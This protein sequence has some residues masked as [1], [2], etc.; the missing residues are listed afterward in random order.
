MFTGIIEKTGVIKK[1][2]PRYLIIGVE[3][4]LSDLKIGDSVAVNG[5]CLTIIKLNKNDFKVEIMPETLHLTNFFYLKQGEAVNLEKSLKAGD[6]LDGHFVLG[7]IDGVGKVIKIKKDGQFI[8]LIIKAPTNL[9]KYIA[10]KGAI[11]VNGIS[12]T[13]AEDLKNSFRVALITRTREVTNLKNIKEGDLV[14]LEID[15]LAR[16]LEKLSK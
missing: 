10:K 7:H 14:N 2:E 11:A 16:Y 4:F 1:I 15:I 9:R 8:D 12:L 13:I 5:V 3:N 6:R